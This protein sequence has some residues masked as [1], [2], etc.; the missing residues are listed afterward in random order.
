MHIAVLIVGFKNVGDIVSCLRALERSTHTDFAVVICENGGPDAYAALTRAL[1]SSLPGGQAVTAILAPGNLGYGGG[2]NV[3][4]RATQAA[5]AWWVLNPDCEPE[6]RAMQA[7]VE[8]LAAGDVEAV[9]S[10]IVLLNGRIQSYG[11]LWQRW[12]AR[13]VSI[14]YGE[15][16][17]IR[18]DPIKIETAQNYLNGASMMVG[19]RFMDQVGPMREDYFLY[20]EEVEWFLRGKRRKMRLGFAPD[21]VVLHHQGTTTGN[22]SEIT[23]RPRS[24]VYLNQRNAMLLTRDCYPAAL[25]LV[26]IGAIVGIL[27]RYGRRGAWKQTGYALEGWWAGL[28]NRRGAPS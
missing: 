16:A 4:L 27:L 26:A 10:T 20:C 6:P 14:G 17:E 2:V 25:P 12:L 5:D 13:A 9:G 11:G 8:R 19:R 15:I 3:G 21:A 1:P 22:V 23:N 7:M 24:P 28:L 18:P